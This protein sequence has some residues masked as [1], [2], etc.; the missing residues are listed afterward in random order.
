MK[1]N[2][3]NEGKRQK[4]RRQITQLLRV[5][6]VICLGF[7]CF[8]SKNKEIPYFVSVLRPP[9]ALL[10]SLEICV[11]SLCA[12][13]S[14]LLA[15][16]IFFFLS[17]IFSWYIL[18]VF[19]LPFLDS[20]LDVVLFHLVFFLCG[21]DALCCFLRFSCDSIGVWCVSDTYADH[22]LFFSRT[23]FASGLMYI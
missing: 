17:C 14:C 20:D 23:Q 3:E 8:W 7:N 15:F 4:D 13:L 5:L 1:K 9:P 19:L 21:Y 2:N 12:L 18:N 11:F 6:L 10:A 16:N 22:T